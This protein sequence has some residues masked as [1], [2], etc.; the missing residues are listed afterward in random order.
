[1]KGLMA[2]EIGT[3]IAEWLVLGAG[4]LVLTDIPVSV[5]NIKVHSM[6]IE[7][8]NQ[9]T[10]SQK[11][12]IHSP[13]DFQKSYGNRDWNW[14]RGLLAT[15]IRYGMPGTWLD[16]GAGLGLFVECAR[17]FGIDCIGLEGSEYAVKL[18]KKRRPDIDIR[19][20]CLDD[21]FPF[22]NNSI[23]TIMCHQTIEHVCPEV[24]NFMLKECYRVLIKE[25]VI[26]IY[27]PCM[28]DKKQRVEERHINLYNPSRLRTELKEAGF[29]NTEANNSSRMI[30]GNC[31]IARYIMQGVFKLFPFDFLSASAN[32]IAV[33]PA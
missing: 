6:P 13:G 17:R 15:S 5:L 14:Y 20:H 8:K 24:A 23:S 1:M 19:Q 33:K 26:L 30:L 31:R 10:A 11:S 16:L 28:Y 3:G 29:V 18:A 12:N 7:S 25:G 4:S 32:C 21:K 27:S 22:E 9:Q 2:I